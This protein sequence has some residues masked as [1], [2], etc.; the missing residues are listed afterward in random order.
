MTPTRWICPAC[1]YDQ[2]DEAPWS[3]DGA[4]SDEICPSCGIHF[5]YDDAAGGDISARPLIYAG[6]RADWRSRG[7]PWFSSATP[8]PANW[9]P[10]Q[11][12]KRV[13]PP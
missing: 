9:N 13:A 11:Q 3:N 8:P 7:C 10:D 4:P 12:L 1:G 6:W 2:L 5:G